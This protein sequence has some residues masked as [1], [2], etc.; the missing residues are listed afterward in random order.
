M[1]TQHVFAA[2]IVALTLTP[3][4]LSVGTF[5]V[6]PLVMLLL[7]FLPVIAVLGLS[8]LVV[9]GARAAAP[10]RLRAGSLPTTVICSTR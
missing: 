1:K 5:I 7:A 6:V 10:M 4:V 9:S 8:M 3:V 2:V